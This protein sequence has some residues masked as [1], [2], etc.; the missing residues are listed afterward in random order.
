MSSIKR[1]L[2]CILCVAVILNPGFLFAQLTL[3]NKKVIKDS[4]VLRISV[5]KHDL[6]NQSVNVS[7]QAKTTIEKEPYLWAT[8]W[9]NKNGMPDS[10]NN[11]MDGVAYRSEAY[12]YDK[13][14]V[15]IM[16]EVVN[17]KGEITWLKKV[18]KLSKGNTLYSTY[19]KTGLKES[20][21][22]NKRGH[23][24]LSKR[25]VNPVVLGYDSVVFVQDN[26]P[27]NST[28]AYFAN[29][30]ISHKLTKNWVGSGPDSFYQSFYQSNAE[31]GRMPS[32]QV[33]FE[34]NDSGQVVVPNTFPFPKMFESVTYRNRFL[35]CPS[36]SEKIDNMLI[37]KSLIKQSETF[38][39]KTPKAVLRHYYTFDYAFH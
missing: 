6:P 17:E 32:Y 13:K 4:S 10:M 27:F 2:P 31:S 20:T 23:I 34:V 39:L 30:E 38:E 14:G 9:F 21:Y 37:G 15:L 18:S 12:T 16:I 11:Y 29:G 19:G 5:T 8:Y 7:N 35:H 25:F 3:P 26:E 33:G 28:E 1:L 22:C 24:Y 36:L